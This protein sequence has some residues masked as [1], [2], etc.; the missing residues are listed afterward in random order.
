MSGDT[1]YGLSDGAIRWLVDGEHGRSSRAI[2]DRLAL[3]RHVEPFTEPADLDDFQRC[4]RLLR[5]APEL[6]ESLVLM[7]GVGPHWRPLIEVW[8]ELVAVLDQDAPGL[9]DIGWAAL[10]GK[11]REKVLRRARVMFET[12]RDKGWAAYRAN[13]LAPA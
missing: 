8:D 11:P 1:G 9:C 6:R 2:F 12:A 3:G 5:M 7:A 13:G 4:E 10:A